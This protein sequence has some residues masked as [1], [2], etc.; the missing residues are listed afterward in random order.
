V[1]VVNVDPPQASDRVAS[2]KTIALAHSD[3][4]IR[5][6]RAKRVPLSST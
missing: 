2:G 3:D 4:F 6:H 1:P 5:R